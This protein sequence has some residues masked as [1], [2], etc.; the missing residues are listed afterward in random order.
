MEITK[1]RKSNLELLRIISMFIIIAHHYIINSG[2]WSALDYNNISGN[3]IF[4]QIWGWGGKAAINIFVFISAYFMCK[5]KLTWK[6]V[7]KLYLEI[8]FYTLIIYGIFLVSGYATFSLKT[9][10]KTLFNVLYDVNNGFTGSFLFFYLM[11]PFL[12]RFVSSVSKEMHKKLIAVLLFTFTIASTFF[13]QEAV[14]NPIGWYIT[15]YFIA[16]YI[17]FYPN[18]FTETKKY[19]MVVLVIS[20]ILII[21][22][23]LVV[24]FVGAK[25]GMTAVYYMFYD[26]HKLLALTFALS[27]FIVFK[28]WNL[29]YNKFINTVAASTFGVFL[30]HTSGSEIRQFLWNDLLNNVGAYHSSMFPI[31]AILSTIGIFVICT[32]ID[33]IRIHILE[34]PLFRKLDSIKGLNKECF[35]DKED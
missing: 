9:A 6:K 2:I 26:S 14:W 11:I 27:I 22:S 18:K 35:V 19:A 3:M 16:S 32:M 12:N 24:D 8:K 21:S 34:R 33:Y 7:L 25:Y 5:G 23:I 29:K 17:R 10:V 28:N 13:L 1:Q 30:I 15:L 20:S 31:H 4:A